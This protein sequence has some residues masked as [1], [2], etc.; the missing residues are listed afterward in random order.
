MKNSGQIT[1]TT[2]TGNRSSGT[3]RPRN[4]EQ[5]ERAANSIHVG[6]GRAPKFYSRLGANMLHGAG[7]RKPTHDEIL[8]TGLGLATRFAISAACIMERDN[9]GYIS[10]IETSYFPSTRGVLRRVPKITIKM[11]KDP[12]NG[13]TQT[14]AENHQESCQATGN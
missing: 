12:V 5:P 7:D 1:T 3:A 10:S 11:V 14:S 13:R 6:V 8:I 2:T 4:A 9:Q